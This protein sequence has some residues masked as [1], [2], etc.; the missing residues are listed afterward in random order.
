MGNDL[1]WR[2]KLVVIEL[3]LKGGK[4]CGFDEQKKEL[5]TVCGQIAVF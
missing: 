5:I 1:V 4:I 3:L 2:M